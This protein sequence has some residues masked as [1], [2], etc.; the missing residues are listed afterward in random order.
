MSKVTVVT[1]SAGNILAMGLGHLSEKSAMKSGSRESQ[2]GLRAGPGQKLHELEIPEN[3]ESVK[4][5]REFHE[6][7]RRHV[8]Q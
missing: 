7:V 8:K 6:K 1:D 2:A 5:Y 3:L 4:N